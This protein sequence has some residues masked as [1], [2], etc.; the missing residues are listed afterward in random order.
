MPGQNNAAQ[1]S[2][3]ISN[4][5][6]KGN[7][8]AVSTT[9]DGAN[10]L[11]VNPGNGTLEKGASQDIAV[12]ATTTNL[13]V[14]TYTGHIAIGNPANAAHIDVALVVTNTPQAK[15]CLTVNTGQI[16][17]SANAQGSN[18]AA[19]GITV[20]NGCGAGSWSATTDQSWLGLSAVGGNVGAKSSM[21][22]NVQANIANLTA[23]KYTGHVTFYPGTATVTVTLNVQPAPCISVQ[24][25]PN[26]IS[27]M[28]G[29]TSANATARVV[30]SNGA[31]C[32]AGTWTAQSDVS[33]I[34]LNTSSG[35]L[36][37]GASSVISVNIN[38]NAVGTG[39]FS[40]HITF[41]PGSGSSVMTINLTVYR[42]LCITA[43]TTSATSTTSL[44][45]SDY[46]G[47]SPTPASQTFTVTNCGNTGT[48]SISNITTSDNIGWLHATGGGMLNAN[49][50]QT[51]T[52]TV[53]AG[54]TAGTILV[55]YIFPS[56][57]VMEERLHLF[58]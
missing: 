39:T 15:P 25:S 3:T 54:S 23:G 11:S 28:E 43:S 1:Q 34:T 55:R 19:Q 2:V 20:T 42:R 36:N 14:G 12:I 29:S 26:N 13:V 50:S 27:V 30:F 41:S 6:E 45:F 18:P 16:T 31:N 47:R 17:F 5:G 33:W 4:C 35:F 9:D 51:F 58:R 32:V 49:S 7:W 48:L 46:I 40:G 57:E 52:V 22:L 8:S 21:N 56:R 53:S 44:T 37:A 38:E 10:W 24:G